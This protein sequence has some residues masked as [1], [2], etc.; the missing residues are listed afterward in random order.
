MIKVEVEALVTYICWLTN[1]DEQKVRKYAKE[2]EV[3]IDDAVNDLRG[4]SEINIYAGDQTDS[5]CSTQKVRVTEW[6]DE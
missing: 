6:D 1:E 3:T 4:E 2:N 5:D